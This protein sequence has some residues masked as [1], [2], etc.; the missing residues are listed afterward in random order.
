MGSG[1]GPVHALE[2][3]AEAAGLT[4]QAGGGVEAD[5]LGLQEAVVGALRGARLGLGLPGE[6]RVVHLAALSEQQPDVCGNLVPSFNLHYVPDHQ[7]LCRNDLL[8]RIAKD[9]RLLRDHLTEAGHDV[10]TL[11]LLVVSKDARQQD[12]QDEHG[13]Q[14]HA[15]Q[16]RGLV[17]GI[18]NSKSDP[19]QDGAHPQEEGEPPHHLLQELDD[20]GGLLGRG[21]GVGA[22]LGQQ[23]C[24]LSAGEALRGQN[25][26]N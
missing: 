25:R 22:M 8:L 14:V 1:A 21:Q 5:V 4:F 12:D 15:V 10:G 11:G 23:L 9:K 20:L 6:R 26:D 24:R 16:G 17:A 18:L 13:A 3:E 2:A 7:L 19:A